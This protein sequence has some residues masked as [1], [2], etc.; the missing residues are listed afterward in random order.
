[1]V[2]SDG[3]NLIPGERYGIK[4]KV[5]LL[6]NQGKGK[7]SGRTGIRIIKEK[8]PINLCFKRAVVFSQI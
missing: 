2:F 5:L 4:L 8:L 3:L 7:V 6:G 1:M